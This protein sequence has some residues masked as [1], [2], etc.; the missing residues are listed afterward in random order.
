[1]FDQIS[2]RYD[3]LN[4][5]LSLGID[6]RWRRRTVD[7]LEPRP[8][9]R[10]LDVATGTADLALMA[11]RRHPGVRVDGVDP[12]PNMLAV[13][14][15]KVAAARLDGAV[16]LREGR[17]EDLPWPTG[18]FDAAMIAF[19]IR[20]VPD[21]ERGL[22]EMTRVTRTGGRVAVLE[23]VEPRRGPLAPAARLWVHH[24]VPALGG[25]L[26]GAPEYRYLQR[27]MAAFPPPEQFLDVMR[28]AGLRDLTIHRLGL[29]T[30]ALLVGRVPPREER[31]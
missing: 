1:M 10:L 4:R 17:A 23:L 2:T 3:L 15:R 11:A 7:A 31:R 13:G 8:G 30:C 25:L 9:H 29:G 14:R 28:A 21:R 12:S 6:Q 20:N 26:S 27:S 22:A 16:A 24:A 18:T 19:G 5:L